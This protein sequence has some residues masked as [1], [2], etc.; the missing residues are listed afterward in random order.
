MALKGVLDWQFVRLQIGDRGRN[1]LEVDIDR[2]LLLNVEV[3][4]LFRV[5][6]R[7]TKPMTD[8]TPI[9]FH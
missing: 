2:L 9:A 1:I 5:N 8:A 7:T 3:V 6:P 4:G